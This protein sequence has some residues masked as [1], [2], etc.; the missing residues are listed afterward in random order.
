MF[1]TDT[2]GFE[3]VLK[4]LVVDQRSDLTPLRAFVVAHQPNQIF[5]PGTVPAYSNYG[6]DLAGYIVE[7]VSGRPFDDYIQENIFRPLGITHATFLQPIPEA[8]TPMLSNGY[9]V[10]SGDAKPFELLPPQ[11]APDGSLS[12][13]GADMA[14]FMIAHLQN[15]KSAEAT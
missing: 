6:A 1:M 10:A 8:L 13:T 3:G 11:A 7:R 9:E 15:G 14:K 4:D 12:I 5:I 2:G